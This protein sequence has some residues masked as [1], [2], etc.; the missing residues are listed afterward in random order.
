MTK[1]LIDQA[2]QFFENCKA[3]FD[4]IEAGTEPPQDV[5]HELDLLV[6]NGG[7]CLLLH[8]SGM[9]HDAIATERQALDP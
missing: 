4:H 5:K 3:I 8:Y 6:A 2:T 1:H 9:L 7:E